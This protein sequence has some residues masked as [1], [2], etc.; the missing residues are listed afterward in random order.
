LSSS[1]RKEKRKEKKDRTAQLHGVCVR[2]GHTERDQRTGGEGRREANEERTR[3]KDWLKKA[4]FWAIRGVFST[5]KRT[6]YK[7]TNTLNVIS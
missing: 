3:K 2:C 4:L 7:Y 1:Q 6:F 5:K